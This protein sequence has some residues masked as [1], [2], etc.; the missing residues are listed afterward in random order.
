MASCV[1]LL[2]SLVLCCC[3][4]CCVVVVGV[5]VVCSSSLLS[6]FLSFLLRA[7]RKEKK[8]RVHIP[9]ERIFV[10]LFAAV[11]ISFCV[12]SILLLLGVLILR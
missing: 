8:L 1:L 7:V 9:R 12:S 6:F 3:R 4:C 5:V 2:L 10:F 11:G